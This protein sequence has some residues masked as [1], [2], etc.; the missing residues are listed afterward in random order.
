MQFQTSIIFGSV[1][2]SALFMT[3]INEFYIHRWM[4]DGD[5]YTD[6]SEM[7]LGFVLCLADSTNEA[8]WLSGST[9]GSRSANIF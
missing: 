7:S 5:C 6:H 8:L 4:D 2:A 3:A 1:R 9:N